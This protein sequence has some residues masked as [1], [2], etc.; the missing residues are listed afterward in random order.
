MSWEDSGRKRLLVLPR[1]A[2]SAGSGSTLSM[3]PNA[4]YCSTEAD[5]LP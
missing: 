2:D 3:T 4:V 5:D 1:Q